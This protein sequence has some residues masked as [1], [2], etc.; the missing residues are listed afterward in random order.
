M[1]ILGQSLFWNE[2]AAQSGPL[3]EI[4]TWQQVPVLFVPLVIIG[5]QYNFKMVM[6]YCLATAAF[7][8]ALNAFTFGLS[9]SRFTLLFSMIFIRTLCFIPVG[10]MVTRLLAV[11]RTQQRALAQAN[12]QLAHYA[13]TLEH[14]AT[15]RERN[16]LARELHDTLAHTLS[17]VAVQLE[18]VRTLW[19]TKPEAAHATLE[20]ALSATRSGLTETRRTLQALR[21][22]P[23]EDLGLPLALRHLAELTAERAGLSLEAD[24]P[25]RV[26]DLPPD[27]E[28]T[29]YR[30]AQ[31]SLANILR[32]AGARHL[33]MGLVQTPRRFT[34]TVTDD[35]KGFD[36]AAI[37]HDKQYG[38]R[39]MQERAE[40]IGGRLEVESQLGHGSSVRFT[41]E[42]TNDTRTDL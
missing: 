9:D 7:E 21:A 41:W 18:A 8:V 14:L 40:M 27:V 19:T 39:G 6:V 16:R 42:N 32:H 1:P 31:E 29:V 4:S 28:Q 34:L 37:N 36:P 24:L 38:I 10:Y 15:S 30:I 25:T 5:W 13:V 35:G 12:A 20:E 11:Q 26:E 33:R 17:G 23:L 22:A 2:R 3:A